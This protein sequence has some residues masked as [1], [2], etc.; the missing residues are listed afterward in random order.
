MKI[1]V[2]QAVG[3]DVAI[4]Q[5]VVQ[6]IVEDEDG[7]PVTVISELQPGVIEVATADEGAEFQRILQGLG[8]DKTVVC[9][10]FD[11]ESLRV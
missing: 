6:L 11:S 3:K 8:I 10:K 5:D 4:L 7:N 1:K 9:Q 2:L